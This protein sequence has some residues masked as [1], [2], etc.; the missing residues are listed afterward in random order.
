MSLYELF[1][2]LKN[3]MFQYTVSSTNDQLCYQFTDNDD[4][5]RCSRKLYDQLGNST[6]GLVMC[7]TYDNSSRHYHLRITSAD[8]D[9]LR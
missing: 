6:S 3:K 4:N 5:L 2:K 9:E 8:T 1:H 7:L